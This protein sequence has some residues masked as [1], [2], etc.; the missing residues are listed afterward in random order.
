MTESS[1]DLGVISESPAE[2]VSDVNP[3]SSAGNETK[4]VGTA[5]DAVNAALGQAEDAT[6]APAEQDSKEPEP[7]KEGEEPKSEPDEMS[8][9]EMKQFTASQQHR[10][11]E[12]AAQTKAAKGT[13]ETLQHE[14]ESVKPKAEQ[15]DRLVGYMQQHEIAPDHLNNALSLTAMINQG[16]YRQ[17]IP[18]LEGLLGQVRAAAGEVLP[19]DLQQRVNL[20][21]LTEA[22]AKE[23]HKA[24]TS[25]RNTV[26]RVQRDRERDHAERVQREQQ[27][28][29]TR[30]V[31]TAEA[32]HQEQVTSDPDWNLKRDR[33]TEKMELEL[34]RLGAEGYPRTDADVRKLLEKVKADVETEIQR[35]RPA[36]KPITTA[37]GGSVSPRSMAKPRT[38][39]EAVELA[40]AG[41]E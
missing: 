4:G 5:L 13:A 32:W 33:V 1:P 20:G 27:A 35:F 2:T 30:A 40:L 34:R 11:R 12:L 41:G 8:E 7:E 37:T 24:R 3:E 10:I 28:T 19:D 39:M 38:P 16:D 25:E 9:E 6:P 21:Y 15:M 23:L 29:V 26:A 22:D 31:N 36:P 17:A 18:I 14:L